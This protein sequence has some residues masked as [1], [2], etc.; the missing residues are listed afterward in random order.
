MK[1]REPVTVFLL[2][3]GLAIVLTSIVATNSKVEEAA[4]RQ[5]RETP[6]FNR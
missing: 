4:R 5:R 3:V 2:I 1:L 6:P